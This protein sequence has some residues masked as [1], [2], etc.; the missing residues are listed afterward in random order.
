V[1]HYTGRPREVHGVSDQWRLF[2]DT[3]GTFTDCI[4][5]A[6]DGATHRAKVL[7]SGALRGRVLEIID[8]RRLRVEVSWPVCDDLVKGF[9]LRLLDR[10][11]PALQVSGFDAR[12]RIVALADRHRDPQRGAAFEVS[13]SEPA[14]LLAARLAT[15]TPAGSALPPAS[16]RLATT[17]GTNALLER[18][19]ARTALFI[20]EGFG[21]LLRIGDQQRPDLFAL[22]VIKP[23]PLYEAVIEVPERMDAGGDVLRP[24]ELP[25]VIER[26]RALCEQGIRAAAVALMHSYRNPAH[27]TALAKALQ[28]IGYEFIS[29]SS[30]LAP[31]IKLLPRAE[32][33][34]VDAYLG[35]VVAAHLA[36]VEAGLGSGRLHAMTSA[37][38]LVR[39]DT[40]SA[41]DSLLS[42]PAGGVAG[43]AAAG[44]RSGFDR[45]IGFDMGGTS[46]DVARFDG[47]YEYRFE[48]TVGGARLV[49]PA[50]AIE[51]VAAGGG[52][53]CSLDRG[54]LR[55]GPE[56]AAADPGP[57]CYGAGGPLTLTDVNLLLGRLDPDG[58]E[59]P[60]DI[61]RSRAALVELCASIEQ[62]TGASPDPH[63]ILAGLLDIANARMADAIEQVSIR[64][65]YDPAEYALVAFGG[66]GGQHACAIADR[67]DM[68]TVILPAD[69]SLL[70]AHGL[71]DAVIERF[72]QHQV[73]APLDQIGDRLEMWLDELASD[74]SR[75]VA[76]EGIEPDRIVIRR[77]LAHLR[78]V[79]Q[80][81]SLTV[82]I[83]DPRDLREHFASRYRAMYGHEPPERP[84]EVESL[85]VVASADAEVPLPAT[86]HVD[87][88][89]P[90]AART[91]RMRLDDDWRGVPAFERNE[92]AIGATVNGPSAIFERHSAFVI[93]RG[94]RATVNHAGAIVAR[95]RDGSHANSSVAARSRQ[96]ELVQQELFTN[97]LTS[98]AREM[99]EMLQRTA[100]STN[101]KERLDFSCALL[102][103]N[104]ELVVNAPHIP[105]HLGA[106][107]L[108]V[109]A[110][111][112]RIAMR[113]G[114]VIVTN[115][116]GFGGSHLPDVTVVT[117]V[118]DDDALLLG[119]V[120]S[121]A[122]H[123]EIG[124]TRPGSMPPDA[125]SLAEEGVVIAPMHLVDRGEARFDRIE[126]RLRNAPHPT[127]AI[128]DNL[129]DLR[130]QAAANH[131]G[132]DALRGLAQIHGAEDLARRMAHL[133]ERAERLTRAALRRLD[134]GRYHALETLDDGS[135]IAVSI[136]LLGDAAAI[137]FT[138]SAE[139]H[140]GNLNATPAIVHSAVLY[141]LRLLIGEDLP[142]NEG[143]M[144]AV[145]LRIPTGMLDPPFVENASQCPAVVGGNVETSQRV[146][147][148]LIKA[149]RLCACGQG[150]MNNV[151]FGTDAF[152]YY[153]TVCGGCGAGPGFDGA[154]AV[155]S[156]MTNTRITDP[157]IVEH[158]RP[159]R[160]ERFAIRT[161]SGGAGRWRG[162]NG[163][164]RQY[165]FLGP[166]SLSVLSQH[167]SVEPFG[168]DG[169]EP[170]RA[171]A[172]RVIRAGGAV[173]ELGSCAGCGVA[174]GDRLVL[175]TPGGGGWGI[176][177]KTPEK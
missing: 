45:V 107:G 142:L 37:G 50:L 11:E 116:P 122:H 173:I 51:T 47:A 77:R 135:P 128:E 43:A 105:V 93:E 150:T 154:D 8:D 5:R 18:R 78:L 20:T 163:V 176:R 171:G 177:V 55:V 69:A 46:T 90:R 79:G 104:A 75:E 94:W 52:S 72:A 120:A 2:I 71:A 35:P 153:E 123:A 36:E 81:T 6:P 85:R 41:K 152:A 145:S 111:R 100:V 14:P 30:R 61:A 169:G 103:R 118:F 23:E 112:V 17:R 49:A 164:L 137:D 60:I 168:M 15:Q 57:A 147:D 24:I 48:H 56:S 26:A 121:R 21:D 108:C 39:A 144:R 157:E 158:R 12:H 89:W 140:R 106:M 27:E 67:L 63:A 34:V 161:G 124:G 136:D 174:V 159:V 33:A 175:E 82:E 99:G 86:Q 80:E 172:Q 133:A 73:L 166:M 129:A 97:R 54:Q 101:V 127:R 131:R 3:G 83:A 9:R 59:I 149:L 44:R 87:T 119:Y 109:R 162:G 13:S 53:I 64:R 125:T 146:V 10:D 84:I 115:H 139:V 28:E 65:G 155:H 29:C 1:C 38:G 4:A 31:L 126:R 110:L 167:R 96:P 92:L 25:P 95:R 130:A 88:S 113:P 151:L 32:T 117:P 160:L 7:S 76:E 156:H 16:M 91:I 40:Y 68:R 138:G 165:R 66:A 74:A 170:G 22:N 102:D 114:D 98:I 62:E 70:S 148:T 19:G 141:V 132:A 42:G 58:F 134:D 143:I